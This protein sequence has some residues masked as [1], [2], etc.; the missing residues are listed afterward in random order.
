MKTPQCTNGAV[1]RQ[2]GMLAGKQSTPKNLLGFGK[3]PRSES[4]SLFG[5]YQGRMA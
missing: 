3:R 4:R 5:Q 2:R 1:V